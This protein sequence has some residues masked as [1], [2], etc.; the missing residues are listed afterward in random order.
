MLAD[1]L[2]ASAFVDAVLFVEMHGGYFVLAAEAGK[3][4][5][6]VAEA[7]GIE[8]GQGDAQ[9]GQ[10]QVEVAPALAETK[11]RLVEQTNSI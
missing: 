11:M 9:P 4:L 10:V 2:V 6:A 1:C 7:A 3:H 5:N 8:K